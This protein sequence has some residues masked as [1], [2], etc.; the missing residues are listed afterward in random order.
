L[1]A[2]FGGGICG[3]YAAKRPAD[4]HRL[5]LLNPQLDY[6][7]RTIDTR[8]YWSDDRISDDAARQLAEHGYIDFTPSLRHGRA[9]FNEVFWLRRHPRP[10]R[11]LAGAPDP[12]PPPQTGHRHRQVTASASAAARLVRDH[13][14]RNSDRGQCRPRVTVLP[15]GLA[16]PLLAQRPRRR[17]GQPVG[18]GRLGGVPRVL[19]ELPTQ[20]SDLRR[21][22]RQLATQLPDHRIALRQRTGHHRKLLTQ[23]HNGSGLLGH[24]AII[25]IISAR[26]SCHAVADLTS[27]VCL[28]PPW[29]TSRPFSIARD[30]GRGSVEWMS[31]TSVGKRRKSHT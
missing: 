17:F 29:D 13:L 10:H 6:K 25:N 31:G 16:S 9:I 30:S 7:K 18:T 19:P 8:P 21:G 26:S 28:T 27:Y 14:V 22:R 12:P 15:T 2:S 23:L 20:L 1:G 5:V 11:D 24:R 3:Y 4:V